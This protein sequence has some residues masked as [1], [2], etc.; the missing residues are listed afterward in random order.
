MPQF[1]SRKTTLV[2][3]NAFPKSRVSLVINSSYF[4]MLKLKM[5]QKISKEIH[6]TNLDIPKRSDNP[7]MMG[8][9]AKIKSKTFEAKD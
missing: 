6:N 7:Q 8:S 5:L 9:T 4:L 2:G 3:Q 1:T